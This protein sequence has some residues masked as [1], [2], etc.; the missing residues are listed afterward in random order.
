MTKA[1]SNCELLRGLNAQQAQA[2]AHGDGP[3]LIIAG[4][5]TGKTR[6]LVHRVAHLIER[7]ID[8][9]RILLVTFTRRAAGEMLRRVDGLLRRQTDAHD[10]QPAPGRAYANAIAKKLWGGT[11]HSVATRLLRAYGKSIGL[12]PAFTIHDRGDSE[13][14]LSVVRTELGLAKTDKRFPKKGTCLAIYSHT[15]NSRRPLEDVLADVYPWCKDYTAELKRLFRAY[16]DRKEAASVLDYD[17]LLLFWRG[18]LA[19]AQAGEIV[20]RRFDCVL[21]DEYQDTNHLQSEI[22]QLLRPD[23]QGLTVVG[24]DAQSIYS[25]RAA[26]VRNILDFPRQFPDTTVVKLEQNYRSVRPVLEAANQVI[27]Q[28]RERFTKDLWTEREAGQRP[29]LVTCND[30]DEQAEFLIERILEHREAG[31]DLRRQAVL[32][33]TSHHSMVLE[34]ELARHNIPFVKY[35][36]L[37]FVETAHVKDLMAILRLAENPRDLVAGSRLLTL[38]PGI[39]PKRA[40][41]LMDILLTAGGKFDAWA[42]VKPPPA[43]DAVWPKLVALMISLA[44]MPA[45]EVASQLHAARKFYAPLLDEKYDNTAPRQRDLEQL[46]QLAARFPDRAAMLAEIALDPPT[47]AED[48]AGDPHLDE[49]YLVLS[50]I[51]SAKGLE[52]DAVYVIH[53]SDGNIPSDMSTGS[54]AQIEEELRL[55]YVALTRAKDWLYVCFPQRYFHA[56]RGSRADRFGYAQLTRFLPKDIR[57]QFHCR[58]AAVLELDREAD[59]SQ[60]AKARKCIRAEVKAMWA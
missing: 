23:G 3:L 38:L 42:C 45:T 25:F 27:A 40:R 17:D 56:F 9:G 35:G 60:T 58:V 44:E 20:R 22:L 11:F 41:Q 50:T 10:S 12:E 51:H 6:T 5:G 13:D 18:L 14:L 33:R 4:A 57:T 26:T 54:P 36:G 53:A 52:W 49:D 15:V 19:D 16:V 55:F 7:G 28:A 8:P 2:A 31:I 29:A 48:W 47:T 30:E 21:V 32:F 34:A 43:A 24:D 37:K 59:E 39:G 46:E 1:T